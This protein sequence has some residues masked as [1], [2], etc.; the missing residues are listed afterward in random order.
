M[1][2]NEISQLTFEKDAENLF[3]QNLVTF[4]EL[5]EEYTQE[6][7]DADKLAAFESIIVK[8]KKENLTQRGNALR[9]V[10]YAM[11]FLNINEANSSLF[12][13]RV[14]ETLDNDLME[15]LEIKDEE[16]YQLSQVQREQDEKIAIG[17]EKISRGNKIIAYINSVNSEKNLSPE[18]VGTVIA[19]YQSIISLLSTGS[20]GTAYQ[21]VL[22]T[23][24]DGVIMTNEDKIKILSLFDRM[25]SEG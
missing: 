2:W 12:L 9:D 6:M 14:I 4:S 11:Y 21:L 16:I 22:A 1:N 3:L 23:T 13:K 18:Q 19:T 7:L 10:P 15:Q 17:V 25:L 20:L 5:S 24:P 8:L